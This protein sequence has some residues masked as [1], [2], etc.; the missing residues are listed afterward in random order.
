[1]RTNFIMSEVQMLVRT[2]LFLGLALAACNKDKLAEPEPSE[3]LAF[4]R[5]LMSAMPDV[6]HSTECQC[7]KKSL[8][9]CYEE[10]LSGQGARCPDS[11][12]NCIFQGKVAL[13]YKRQGVSDVEAARHS[14]AAAQGK[15]PPPAGV[16]DLGDPHAGHGH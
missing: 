2:I 4:R 1:M 9:T 12:G 10:T 8:W 16:T 7:C 6:L 14:V 15:E 5:Y 3:P 13:T 11:C